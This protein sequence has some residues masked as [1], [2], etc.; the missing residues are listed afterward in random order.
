M[1]QCIQG[2]GRF[3]SQEACEPWSVCA[4]STTH[5]YLGHCERIL[6]LRHGM[7]HDVASRLE[8]A[9]PEQMLGYAA[10]AYSPTMGFEMFAASAG[11]KIGKLVM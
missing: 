4:V 2:Q 9:G 6:P 5:E 1:R 10:Q 8:T 3:C 7:L 11:F